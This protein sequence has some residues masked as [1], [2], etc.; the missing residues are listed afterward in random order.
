MFSIEL[1]PKFNGR[2]ESVAEWFDKLCWI[3]CLHGVSNVAAVLVVR[4][5]GQA[6]KVYAQLT[7]KEK[8]NVDGVQQALVKAFEVDEFSAYDQLVCRRL[9][10]GEPVDVYIA[11]IRR[12]A[13]LSGGLNEKAIVSAFV[14]GLPHHV[15][16]TLRTNARM[17]EMSV[18]QLVESACGIIADDGAAAAGAEL[19]EVRRGECTCTCCRRRRLTAHRDGDTGQLQ[20][21]CRHSPEHVSSS[22]SNEHSGRRSVWC[23]RCRQRGHIAAQCPKKRAARVGLGVGCLS[24]AHGALPTVSLRVNDCLKRVLVDSWCSS[25]I[26]SATCCAKWRDRRT[27]IVTMD[28]TEHRSVG[29][30][31]VCLQSGSCSP[32]FVQALVVDFR[33]LNF[34][35]VLGMTRISSF[36]VDICMFDS[37]QLCGIGEAVIGND[38]YLSCPPS[39]S[40]CPSMQELECLPS[41]GDLIAQGV[42]GNVVDGDVVGVRPDSGYLPSIRELITKE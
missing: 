7:S 39:S 11:D 26:V 30:T 34:E 32:R 40:S 38:Q 3:C 31:T 12:L 1:I 21:C 35:F 14:H 36:D 2:E 10:S 13:E 41:T 33:P 24:F 23:F 8:L 37:S 16:R 20:N 28:G 19:G 15:R 27:T 42:S 6:Y 9:E 5:T 17:T 22:Q 29:V 4:L 25:C 18:Q